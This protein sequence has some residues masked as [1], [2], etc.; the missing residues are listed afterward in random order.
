MDSYRKEM[1]QV[2]RMTEQKMFEFFPLGRI[3]GNWRASI[4]TNK[5]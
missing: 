1:L 4:K 2:S 5:W 3:L